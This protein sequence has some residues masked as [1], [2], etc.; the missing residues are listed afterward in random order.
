M[1]I[2]WMFGG[3]EK[4][5]TGVNIAINETIKELLRLDSHN[6]YYAID[7][8]YLNLPVIQTNIMRCQDFWLKNKNLEMLTA[9]NDIQILH[10]FFDSF[11]AVTYD[12]KKII[13]IH[14]LIPLVH[15][16]WHW[17]RDYFDGPMRASARM[18]DVILADS[19]YTKKEVVK[20]YNIPEE[21]IKVVYFGCNS[22]LLN[23]EQNMSVVDKYGLGEGYI[24]SVSTLE[25]RKN[26]RGLIKAFE[27]YKERHIHSKIKLVLT[28]K[29]GWDESFQ[30]FL[31]SM[32]RVVDDIVITGYV[33]ACTLAGLYKNAIAMAYVSY[34]EGFGLPVLEAYNMGTAVI[35]SDQT[36]IP[37]AGGDAAFYCNPYDKESIV[38]AIEQAVENETLR[39]EKIEKGFSHAQ[40]FSYKNA[41]ENI[42]KIYSSLG[43]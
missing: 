26:L 18:A 14:D 13:T 10:S 29:M 38:N 24:L 9:C 8:N 20:Y 42:L 30:T 17:A 43:A 7:E 16:E 40:K 35:A 2:G 21:K 1:R 28:G 12:C 39:N 32:G 19:Q 3:P 34:Y 5:L 11:H 6:Q 33:D 22:E 31:K 23:Q 25:P 4:E 37:E 15:P 41:A 36:S 27:A